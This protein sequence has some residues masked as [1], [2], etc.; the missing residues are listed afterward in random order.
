MEIN[1]SWTKYYVKIFNT[2]PDFSNYKLRENTATMKSR[3]Q[4]KTEE[5]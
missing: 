1:N 3:L 4:H 2:E 5:Y